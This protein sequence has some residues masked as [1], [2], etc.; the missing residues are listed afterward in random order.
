MIRDRIRD[1]IPEEMPMTLAEMTTEDLLMTDDAPALLPDAGTLILTRTMKE[2]MITLAETTILVETTILAEMT[3]LAE[4]Q[5]EIT[6]EETTEETKEKDT[7]IVVVKKKY[8]PWTFYLWTSSVVFVVRDS[9][10]NP[11]ANSSDNNA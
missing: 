5:E 2:E 1:R 8:N 9:A 10:C 4:T 3:I 6:T 7:T 11:C